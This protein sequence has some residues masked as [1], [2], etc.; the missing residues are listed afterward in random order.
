MTANACCYSS[1]TV[2]LAVPSFVHDRLNL[3]CWTFKFPGAKGNDIG[4]STVVRVKY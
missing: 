2:L 1:G 3:V 4:Y